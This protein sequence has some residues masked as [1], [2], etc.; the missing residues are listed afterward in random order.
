MRRIS[1]LLVAALAACS[2]VGPAP[3]ESTTSGGTRRFGVPVT[4]KQAVDIARL[5]KAP[6]K[7]KGRTVRL[8]G[9]VKDV[10]QGRG[11][12]VEVAAPNGASFLAKSLD[13]SVLVPKDCKGRKVVVQGVVTTLPRNEKE[14]EAARAEGHACPAPTYVVSMLGVE[15]A[16]R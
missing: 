12:W 7:F 10:C 6:E 15:L 4:A 13:E 3:A 14:A 8:Q 16:D 5:A 9:V 2:L 11:C 1:L